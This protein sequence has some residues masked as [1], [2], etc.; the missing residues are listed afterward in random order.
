MSRAL[1]LATTGT[2]NDGRTSE[3][4]LILFDLGSGLYG[5]HT[6]LGPFVYNGVTYQGAGSLISVDGVRQTADLGAVQVIARLTA[7]ENTELTP[8]VLATIENEV[9][10]QRPCSIYT[11]YFNPDTGELLSVEIEYR[12]YID[13][14]VHTENIDGQAVLEAHLESRFRDHGKSGYRVRSDS[15]QRRIN[16]NDN[17]LRHAATVATETVKFGRSEQPPP[18]PAKKKNFFQRL[19]G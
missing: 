9:Y 7:I 3:R 14:M 17:S 12:G 2:L 11:A 1:N 5:Y 19:F 8:D 16:A 10:H 6:G 15:D 4:G 13:R 18:A